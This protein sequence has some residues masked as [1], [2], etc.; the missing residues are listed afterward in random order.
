[1]SPGEC[2]TLA[3]VGELNAC[4]DAMDHRGGKVCNFA[5]GPQLSSGGWRFSDE[6]GPYP[7]SEVVEPVHFVLFAPGR[8]SRCEGASSSSKGSWDECR[9]SRRSRTSSSCSASAPRCRSFSRPGRAIFRDLPCSMSLPPHA[10]P[11]AFSSTQAGVPC[12]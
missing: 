11:S 1:M 4:R 7:H 2:F 9:F 6:S 8:E 3:S 12:R 10:H 5:L